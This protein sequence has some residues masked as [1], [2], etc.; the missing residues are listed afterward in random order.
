MNKNRFQ[1]IKYS[2]CPICKKYGIFAFD[3]IGRRYNHILECNY[4]KKKFS[5]NI[6]VSI[7]MK[8]L[9]PLFV[10]AIALIVN[11]YVTKV[12]FLIWAIITLVLWFIFEYFAPLSNAD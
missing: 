8:I 2:K 10:G 3:K 6:V 7:I 11:T 5:V 12:P 9:I 1:K 4:C